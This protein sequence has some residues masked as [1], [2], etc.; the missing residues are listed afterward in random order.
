MGHGPL[1]LPVA[2]SRGGWHSALTAWLPA[3]LVPVGFAFGGLAWV[4]TSWV[5][6]LCSLRTRAPVAGHVLHSSAQPLASAS[7]CV[8]VCMDTEDKGTPY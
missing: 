4:R 6:R 1:L 7:V 2:P 5:G 3:C 8:R